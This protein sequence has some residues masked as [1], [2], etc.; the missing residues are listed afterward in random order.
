M[1]V[2]DVL[3]GLL[4]QNLA[5]HLLAREM[6]LAFAALMLVNAAAML[7]LARDRSAAATP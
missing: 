1:S 7:R 4:Y 2:G 5:P 3:C 6:L